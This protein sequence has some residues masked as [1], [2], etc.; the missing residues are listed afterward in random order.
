MFWLVARLLQTAG[1]KTK[2]VL[3]AFVIALAWAVHP[4]QVSS[5]LYIVQRMEML[6]ATFTLLALLAYL[7]GRLAQRNGRFG[8]NGGA[9]AAEAFPLL[10][11]RRSTE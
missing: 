5:V 7:R 1:M 4:L 8:C 10:F 11:S 2:A 6:V 3:A 9:D